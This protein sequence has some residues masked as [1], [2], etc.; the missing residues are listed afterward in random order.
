MLLINTPP[1]DKQANLNYC[2]AKTVHSLAKLRTANSLSIC[3]LSDTSMRD[4]YCS[5]C[6]YTSPLAVNS[7]RS[8]SGKNIVLHSLCKTSCP[9]RTFHYRIIPN[10]GTPPNRITPPNFEVQFLLLY[11]VCYSCTW[12]SKSNMA[13]F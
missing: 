9:L 4:V 10:K 1:F 2:F 3:V 6:L 7:D 11:H 8:L 12:F 13:S 5:K